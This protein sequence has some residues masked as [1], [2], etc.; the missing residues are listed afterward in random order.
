MQHA[1]RVACL[2][3]LG[4][5]IYRRREDGELVTEQELE[6]AVEPTTP[7]LGVQDHTT[8]QTKSGQQVVNP[9][10]K[11]SEYPSVDLHASSGEVQTEVDKYL[12]FRLVW[13]RADDILMVEALTK[14][15]DAIPRARL[16]RNILI[17]LQLKERIEPEEAM[18]WPFKGAPATSEAAAEMLSGFLAG[19]V[20]QR[21]STKLLLLGETVANLLLGDEMP[22]EEVVGARIKL[23]NGMLETYICPSAETMLESTLAKRQAWNL[24]K[25][26][27]PESKRD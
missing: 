15:T 9:T 13:N 20:E 7:R 24:L 23:L 26:L 4:I 21:P 1:R 6:V 8:A 27:L 2:T 18:E 22:F 3:E 25:K 5:T 19:Q 16:V 10:D 11:N 12:A 14:E 17:A